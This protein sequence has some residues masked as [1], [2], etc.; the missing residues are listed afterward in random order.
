[1][2]CQLVAIIPVAADNTYYASININKTIVE[3]DSVPYEEDGVTMVPMQEYINALGAQFE[4]DFE[5]HKA[6]ITYSGKILDLYEDS[7]EAVL[8]GESITMPKA[9]AKHGSYIYVPLRA[10]AEALG[11]EVV[12]SEEEQS[13]NVAPPVVNKDAGSWYDVVNV[14]C[15]D[16]QN[17][18]NIE[19]NVLDLDYNTRWS[20]ETN[21]A[22]V[23]LELAEVSPVAYVGIA[24]YNGDERQSTVSVQVSEDGENFKEVVTKFVTS[25]TLNMEAMDLGGVQNAKYIR[26]LGYGNTVNNWNSIV[27]LRVYAPQEDGSM[28]VDQSGPGGNNNNSWDNLSADEQAAITKLET[29]FDRVLPWMTNIYDQDEHGFYMAMSGKDDPEQN[30]ALEMT[31]WGISIIKNYTDLW[32]DIP[33]EMRQYWVDYFDDRQD[34]AT[35]YYIDFQGPVNDRETA[36]NQA[37][38]RSAMSILKAKSKYVHPLDKV[39]SSDSTETATVLPDYLDSTDSFIEWIESWGWENNSWTGG[40]QLQQAVGNYLPLLPEDKYDEYVDALWDWLLTNQKENGLWS[41]K[42]NFNSVSGLF[43]VGLTCSALNRQ[44]PNADVALESVAKCF[45]LD[46]PDRAHYVR[47]PLSVMVQIANYGP[48][49]AEKVRKITT[50]N[51]DVILKYIEKFLAPDGGFSMYYQK[52]QS[53]FGGIYGTHQLWEGDID[54]V[55]MIMVARREMYSIYGI[56]APMLHMDGF[57]DILM[58]KTEVPDCYDEK[59]KDILYSGASVEGEED[60]ESYDITEDKLTKFGDSTVNSNITAKIIKDKDRKD[61]KVLS[62]Y[63]DGSQSSGPA[64]TIPVGSGGNAQIKYVPGAGSDKVQVVEFEIRASGVGGTNVAHINLGSTP[65]IALN[66]Q[67]KN[68]ISFGTRVDSNNVA[69]G[70]NFAN[71]GLNEWYKIKVEYKKGT[72]TDDTN[73][74]VYIDEELVY[75]GSGYYGVAGGTAPYDMNGDISVN[76]YRAGSGTIYLDN[77]KMYAK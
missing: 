43:K 38:A 64:F 31:A 11:Y 3:F 71:I 32:T 70:G 68:G 72:N 36:R 51:I 33:E 61:N 22:Y 75:S 57:W 8:D 69:Y 25:V 39:T 74:K 7:A 6:S 29:Y 23:T 34:A 46:S 47:N 26:V 21:G 2:L 44:I 49:Y 1:M 16:R 63:Y 53:N 41:S 20:C 54:S 60:F 13:I 67:P 42:I 59:Y 9:A 73:I 48:E 35:G 17:E 10:V 45:E 12:W 55:M 37:A 18:V 4:W 62:L 28:P 14:T 19:Q 77:F 5:L 58:G 40:D 27:E 15:S 56:K 50:D 24:M 76:Y 65:A 66:L 30:T 52:S